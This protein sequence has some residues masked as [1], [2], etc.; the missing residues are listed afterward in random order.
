MALAA[1][2]GVQLRSAGA[3]VGAQGVG[4]L[5]FVLGST[6]L[7]KDLSDSG[8]DIS[9][10]LWEI[11]GM[12]VLWWGKRRGRWRRTWLWNSSRIYTQAEATTKTGSLALMWPQ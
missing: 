7:V 9:A 10:R 8:A 3:E 6:V 4:V 2:N 5:G 11:K 12:L 1:A